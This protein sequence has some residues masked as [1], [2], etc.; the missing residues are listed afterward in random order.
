MFTIS[1]SIDPVL[2]LRWV[3]V[4]VFGL[5]SLFGLW[6]S[7]RECLTVDKPTPKEVFGLLLAFAGSIGNAIASVLLLP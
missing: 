4:V 5:L 6:F 7:V 1:F 3:G 2:T